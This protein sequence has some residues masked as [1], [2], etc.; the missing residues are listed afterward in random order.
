MEAN[1]PCGTQIPNFSTTDT[2]ERYVIQQQIVILLHA[3]KCQKN[4]FTHCNLPH[5]NLMKSVIA[6]MKNCQVGETCTSP[7]CSSSRKIID[8]WLS[9]TK[10]D[11]LIC[12]PLK[13]A[14]VNKLV[15][16]FSIS[17]TSISVNTPQAQSTNKDMN[18]L[19]K[20][21]ILEVSRS[22]NGECM[23]FPI[24]DIK[25]IY[26]KKSVTKWEELVSRNMRNY[27]VQKLVLEIIPNPNSEILRER[28]L[29][30][31]IEYAQFIERKI[32][33][34]AE[35]SLIYYALFDEK[36]SN[37]ERELVELRQLYYEEDGEKQCEC[38]SRSCNG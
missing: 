21:R 38:I 18:E 25:S 37:L 4:E 24:E 28:G 10:D 15:H 30:N 36:F 22:S 1:K 5:C 8:H 19:M 7:H 2:Q 12:L 33:E 16:S 6:H 14:N 32:Y 34:M 26:V 17:N 35:S 13:E 29:Q 27:F 9:C 11:C 31:V 23:V 20:S 3:D